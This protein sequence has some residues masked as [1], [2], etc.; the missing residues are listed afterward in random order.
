MFAPGVTVADLDVG[1]FF[2]L[3]MIGLETIGIVM[4]G[5]SSNNKYAHYGGMRAAAQMLS[6][7]IPIGLG[8]LAILLISTGTR[9]TAALSTGSW[10]RSTGL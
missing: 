8:L 2:F 4:A 1:I 5:W 3:A 6:Y 9:P 7:E 10:L